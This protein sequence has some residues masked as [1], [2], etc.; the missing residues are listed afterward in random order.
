MKQI[1]KRLPRV[2]DHLGISFHTH[3]VAIKISTV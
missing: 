2:C 3:I 1:F